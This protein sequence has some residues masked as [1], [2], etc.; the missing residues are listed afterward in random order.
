MCATRQLEARHRGQPVPPLDR[1]RSVWSRDSTDTRPLTRTIAKDVIFPCLPAKPMALFIYMY[2]MRLGML[3]GRAGLRF[4]F[5]HAWYEATVA[6]LRA[7][8]AAAE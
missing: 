3:D 1:L 6:A 7:D 8:I 5:F 4:C 2:V